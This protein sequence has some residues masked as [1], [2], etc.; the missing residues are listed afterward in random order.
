MN[1]EIGIKRIDE[2]LA[3]TDFFRDEVLIGEEG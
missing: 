3:Q 1:F 2:E